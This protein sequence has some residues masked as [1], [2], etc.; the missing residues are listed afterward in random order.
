MIAR[1]ATPAAAM[2]HTSYRTSPLLPAASSAA[3]T[4]LQRH[5]ITGVDADGGMPAAVRLAA[6]TTRTARRP[7]SWGQSQQPR[8]TAELNEGGDFLQHA[9]GLTWGC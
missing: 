9:F 5:A 8:C 2:V 7:D 1:I 3:Q 4:A 6:D